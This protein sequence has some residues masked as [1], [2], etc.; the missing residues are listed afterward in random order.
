MSKDSTIR[1]LLEKQHGNLHDVIPALCTEIGQSATAQ[2][3]GVTQSWVSRW[4]R[5]NG[6]HAQIIYVQTTE[7]ER[8]S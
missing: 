6:Y 2:K 5:D 1:T 7:S 4:L 8:A 3:L